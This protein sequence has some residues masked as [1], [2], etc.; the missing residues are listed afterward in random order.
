MKTILAKQDRKIRLICWKSI[1]FQNIRKELTTVLSI[2]NDLDSD[3]K[4]EEIAAK[5]SISRQY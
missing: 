5:H 4:I 3:L 1:G 2:V